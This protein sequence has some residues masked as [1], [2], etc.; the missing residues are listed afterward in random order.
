MNHFP[1]LYSMM[2]GGGSLSGAAPLTVARWV[3]ALSCAASVMLIGAILDDA[4]TS[5]F[6]ALLGELSIICVVD[7]V[8]RYLFAMTEAPFVMFTLLFIFS[9]R[10]A[11]AEEGSA[12][13]AVAGGAAAAACLTRYVGASL[14][15]TGA[16]VLMYLGAGAIGIRMRRA[17]MFMAIGGLPLA[18]WLIRNRIESK[19]AIDRFADWHPP[20]VADFAFECTT[21]ARWAYPQVSSHHAVWIG[22][23]LIIGGAVMVAAVAWCNP[24]PLQWMLANLII[25]NAALIMLARCLYDPL[26]RL[27]P[28]TLLPILVAGFVLSLCVITVNTARLSGGVL[29]RSIG[30]ALVVAFL[31][32]NLRATAPILYESRVRGLGI[33]DRY[34]ADSDVIRWIRHLP[35]DTAIYS[36][37]PEPIRLFADHFATLLPLLRDPLT[38]QPDK[39]FARNLAAMRD[40]MSERPGAIAYFYQAN[41]WAQ[42]NLPPLPDMP[43]VYHLSM[44]PV[45]QAEQ[46]IIYDARGATAP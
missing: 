3:G 19:H 6:V 26:V 16:S 20:G 1:P 46:G 8:T 2:L 45:L 15:V 24:G 5:P 34:Y 38:H 12:W 33:T 43:S 9:L 10:R 29:W 30:I 25:C 22:L 28:R 18:A 17:T 44:R 35:A 11:I 4:T 7:A 23:L 27:G 37:E 40:A 39:D 14:L 13:L 42:D 41:H 32:V 36:N 31:F 21:V